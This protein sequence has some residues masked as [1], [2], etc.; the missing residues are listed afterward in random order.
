MAGVALDKSYLSGIPNPIAV[1]VAAKENTGPF[2]RLEKTLSQ[3]H[4]SLEA[5]VRTEL[6]KRNTYVLESIQLK[7]T[8]ITHVVYICR[9]VYRQ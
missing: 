3:N 8:Y 9:Y 5:Q 6:E 1:R 7:S 2:L 4:L